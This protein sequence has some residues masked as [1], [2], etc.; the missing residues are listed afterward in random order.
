MNP[1]FAGLLLYGGLY[2]A[3]VFVVA[4][5]HG[6]TAALFSILLGAGITYLSYFV[7]AWGMATPTDPRLR[8][9]GNTLVVASILIG[10]WAGIL[11]FV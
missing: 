1:L 2:T 8:P 9:L 3:G 7:Q 6:N 4:L 11:L 10:S 5:A